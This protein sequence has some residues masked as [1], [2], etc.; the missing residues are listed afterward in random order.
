MA[1]KLRW[2]SSVN[3][4]NINTRQ[5]DPRCF[6]VCYFYNTDISHGE[7]PAPASVAFNSNNNVAE[8]KQ[9]CDLTSVE[10]TVRLI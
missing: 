9:K 4:T 7:L 2:C 5:P 8:I 1:V 6:P 10:D 3:G